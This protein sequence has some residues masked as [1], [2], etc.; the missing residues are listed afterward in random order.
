MS[1]PPLSALPQGAAR[2]EI[3]NEVAIRT[4]KDVRTIESWCEKGLFHSIDL[5]GGYG[6]VWVA[7]T[8]DGWPVNG[9]GVAAY[10][11]RRSEAA[12]LRAAAIAA[13][14]RTSTKR[15]SK[16]TPRRSA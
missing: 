13:K 7:V 14:R 11:Q 3:V 8:A 12:R 5:A 10:R 4:G 16:S 1:S 9:P 2:W 15:S 6:G